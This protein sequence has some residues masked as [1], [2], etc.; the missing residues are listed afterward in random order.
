MLEFFLLMLKARNGEMG[1]RERWG[2]LK[3]GSVKP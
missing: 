2:E 1:A 3:Y